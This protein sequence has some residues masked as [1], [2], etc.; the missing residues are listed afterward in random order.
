MCINLMGKI[1]HEKC[2]GLNSD[3]FD[4]NIMHIN[5]NKRRV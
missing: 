4:D 3:E 2:G 1:M 5:H